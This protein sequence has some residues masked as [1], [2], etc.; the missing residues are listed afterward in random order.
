MVLRAP[1]PLL[2]TWVRTDGTRVDHTT[3]K[4][5]VLVLV[6]QQGAEALLSYEK[7]SGAMTH[8]LNTWDGVR[9]KC[10]ALGVDPAV[11]D[12]KPLP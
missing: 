7:P 3:A 12:R 1:C 2:D 9:R 5:A 11:L 8:T 6:V 4:D 10:A